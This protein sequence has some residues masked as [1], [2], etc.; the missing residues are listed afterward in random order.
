M[1]GVEAYGYGAARRFRKFAV[2]AAL[3][4]G[5]WTGTIHVE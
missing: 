3:D 4:S 5:I 2:E 1:S